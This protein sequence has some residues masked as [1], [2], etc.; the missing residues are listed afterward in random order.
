MSQLA[1]LIGVGS[2]PSL[3]IDLLRSFVLIADG[4]SF[5]RTAAR[6][7]RTQAAVSLQVQKLESLVGHRVFVRKRGGAVS[8]T[9]QGQ[10]L[11]ERARDLL[12]LN[13]EIV[14]SLRAERRA[15]A[16]L[17]QP[18]ATAREPIAVLPVPTNRPSIAVKPF[19]NMSGDPEQDYFAG[20][21]T[22]EIIAGLSRIKWL[23]VVARGSGRNTIDARHVGLN[24][25]ARYLLSGGV[26]K[27]GSRVRINAQLI[28]TET[29]ALLWAD[30]YDGALDDVFTLQDQVTDQVVGIVEPSLQRSEIER[31]RRRRA[32]NLD[33][34]N[35]Y[36]RAL[37]HVAAQMPD[38]AKIAQNLLRQALS[39]DPEYAPAH[40]LLAW[41]HELRFARAGFNVADKNAA[42]M[43]ARAAI[44][45]NTDDSSAL[46]VA[47]FVLNFL[48][49]DHAMGLSAIDRALSINPSCATALHLGAQA[50]A[51]ANHAEQAAVFATRALRLGPYH[52]LAFEAHLAFGLAAIEEARYEDAISCYAAA[53]LANQ[54]FSTAYF[55]RAMALALAGRPAEAGPLVR[56]G[57]ELEPGFRF[58]LFRELG[59]EGALVE[60]LGDGS[61]RLGLPE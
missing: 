25:S 49:A 44:D 41:S 7:G 45:T 47:G 18:V 9:S 4:E 24:A 39:L 13:D 10:F 34:Y 53:T 3:D 37:P 20:G 14:A 8:L 29:G 56:R 55:F 58:R 15:E 51:T 1:N 30:K 26:L 5:T 46:A 28:E 40:A 61:R 60:R 31:S 48:S 42:L 27:A 2:L 23:I 11:L 54:R 35:L 19:R 36:L 32:G 57:Y 16:S 59:M 43:H 6:V 12:A 38:E 22:D 52:P 50:H 21:I 33:A 17:E